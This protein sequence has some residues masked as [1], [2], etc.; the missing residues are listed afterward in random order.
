MACGCNRRHYINSC[1]SSI[2]PGGCLR[3]VGGRY[4][5]SCTSPY[6]YQAQEPYCPYNN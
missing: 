1:Y 2:C 5:C 4:V 3:Y 6:S